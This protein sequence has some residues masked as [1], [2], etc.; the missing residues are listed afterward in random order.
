MKLKTD[1]KSNLFNG[2]I[3]IYLLVIGIF[4]SNGIINFGNG[5]G[6]LA[7]LYSIW[8]FIII[9][10]IL[11]LI[12]YLKEKVN[13]KTKWIIGI[14]FVLIAI[15]YTYSFTIGKGSV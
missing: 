13:N 2:L 4:T 9:Y 1:N 15:Y 6:D 11:I 12:L 10:S 3:F 14:S 5:L 8:L 7:Y